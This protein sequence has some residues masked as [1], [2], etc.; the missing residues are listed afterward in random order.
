MYG[1]YYSLLTINLGNNYTY[2]SDLNITLNK[3]KLWGTSLFSVYLTDL[4]VYHLG[5]FTP[6]S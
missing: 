5:L 4:N 3:K 1:I 2:D 6:K